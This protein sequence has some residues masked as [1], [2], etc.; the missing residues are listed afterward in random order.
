MIC[1]GSCW[2]SSCTPACQATPCLEL[3]THR[4]RCLLCGTHWLFLH[5]T[6]IQLLPFDL[7]KL[8]GLPIGKKKPVSTLNIPNIIISINI[9]WLS[10]RFASVCYYEESTAHVAPW[11]REWR[12]NGWVGGGGYYKQ[13][14]RSHRCST[15]QAG[16]EQQHTN[17]HRSSLLEI[18]TKPLNLCTASKLP[19]TH[20][21]KAA[22]HT[23]ADIDK[24]LLWCI[25][26]ACVWYPLDME[27]YSGNVGHVNCRLVT[28]KLCY[29]GRYCTH[30]KPHNYYLAHTHIGVINP[31]N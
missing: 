31:R 15:G 20:T 6:F 1:G 27:Y 22:G 4:S 29:R 24:L 10:L 25:F 13:C 14:V 8:P 9:T 16:R 5:C 28:D 17:T 30:S 2:Q 12:L 23:P 7:S 18:S 21:T 19:H 11:C 26:G 3:F